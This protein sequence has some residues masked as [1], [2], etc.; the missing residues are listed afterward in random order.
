MNDEIS[1]HIGGDV[2]KKMTASL[3]PELSWRFKNV[4]KVE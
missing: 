2:L 4:L 3:I 1:E